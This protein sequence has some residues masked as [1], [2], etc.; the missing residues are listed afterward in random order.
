M[1]QLIIGLWGPAGVGKDTVA[2]A[3]GFPKASFAARLKE[4]LAPIFSNLGI[5]IRDREQKERVRG[6]MISLGSTARSIDPY[7]W[8]RRVSIP[9]AKVVTF[10]DVRYFNEILALLFR[11]GVVYEL[12]RPG[13]EP[14]N[15]EEK[16]SF[17][18]IRENLTKLGVSIPIIKN[19]TPTQAAYEIVLDLQSR[20]SHYAMPVVSDEHLV[21]VT[22]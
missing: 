14:A 22:F 15:D 2:D 17:A 3:L 10:C 4:D 5:D 19:T 1:N 9:D 8:I 7:H 16:R 11:G 12:E 13:F 21:Q 20:S 18:E 6:L